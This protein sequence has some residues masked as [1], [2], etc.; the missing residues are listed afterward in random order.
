[1]KP[2]VSIIIPTLNRYD[3]LKQ[4]LSAA[5]AVPYPN[6]EI[7]VVDQTPNPGFRIDDFPD[8]PIAY[9]HMK[10][11]NLPLARNVGLDRAK[12]DIILFLDDD[13][14]FSPTLVDEHVNAHL[15]HLKAGAVTGMIKLIAPHFWP[16]QSF[17]VKL[18]KDTAKLHV[19]F[20]KDQAGYI[21]YHSGGNVSFKKEVF[22]RVGAF[23]CHFLGNAFYEEIDFSI[24]LRKK[25]YA[26]FYCPSAQIIHFRHDA[27]GCR[28]ETGSHYYFK[29]FYNT[30]YFFYKHLFSFFPVKFLGAMKNEMEFFSR[31]GQ[32]HDIRSVVAYCVGLLLGALRGFFNRFVA[33]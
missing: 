18:D 19:N 15:Q 6:F 32:G 8:A 28:S 5:L 22:N 33:I 2:F 10:K 1:M 13:I 31:T 21:D 24:R 7:I 14:A 11:A 16:E 29:R 26:I 23:D 25:G 27:G 30:A 9:I 12:G 4:T 3:A 20:E 17:V